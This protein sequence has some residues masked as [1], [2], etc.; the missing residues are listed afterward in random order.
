MSVISYRTSIPGRLADEFAQGFISMSLDR[1][2]HG[3]PI[4]IFLWR[5]DGTGL[6]IQSVMYDIA[7]RLEIG[8]LEFSRVTEKGREL[9]AFDLPEEFR[10]GVKAAKLVLSTSGVTA[11]SGVLLRGSHG[12]ELVMVAGAQPYTIAVKASFIRER[13]EPEYELSTYL[14]EPID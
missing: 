11:D 14:Q 9:P 1:L 10:V 12:D 2:P 13:F 6:K 8:A 3:V 5:A 7:E 4:A